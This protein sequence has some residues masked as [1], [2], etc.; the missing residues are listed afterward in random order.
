MSE[1]PQLNA[2]LREYLK[3][4]RRAQG[5]LLESRA[6]RLRYALF[7]GFADIAPTAERIEAEAEASIRSGKGLRRTEG[8]TAEQEIR[9]RKRSR[10]FLASSFIFPGWKAAKN[11]QNASFTRESKTGRTMGQA[12]VKTS[13]TNASVLIESLLQGAVVQNDQRRIVDQAVAKQIEDMESYIVR[14]QKE[15]FLKTLKGLGPLNV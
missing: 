2:K 15:Q 13:G 7:K 11:G 10:K 4:N 5:P 9:R 1:Y 3:W 8:T 12:V 6:R 14:K